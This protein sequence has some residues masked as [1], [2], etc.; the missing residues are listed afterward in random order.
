M[1]SPSTQNGAGVDKIYLNPPPLEIFPSICSF[2]YYEMHSENVKLGVLKLNFVYFI[3]AGFPG[4]DFGLSRLRLQPDRAPGVLAHSGAQ[5][6]KGFFLDFFAWA[7]FLHA[8]SEKKTL[9]N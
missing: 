2:R 5:G 6:E 1:S 4:F 8:S 3:F 7:K 9:R